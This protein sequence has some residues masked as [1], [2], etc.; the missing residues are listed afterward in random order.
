M[1]GGTRRLQELFFVILY[2]RTIAETSTGHIDVTCT[3]GPGDGDA[4]VFLL[5][6]ARVGE[7]F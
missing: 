7:D 6:G 5:A 3:G 2:Q 4:Y 1:E